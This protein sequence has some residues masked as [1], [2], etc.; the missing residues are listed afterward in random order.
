MK[1]EIS[2]I[3]STQFPTA[4]HDA[5]RYGYLYRKESEIYDS[6]LH[7]SL[8]DASAIMLWIAS[9]VASGVVYDVIKE[10]VKRLYS[11]LKERGEKVDKETET[12]LNDDRALEE[13]TIYVEEYYAHDMKISVEQE[14]Y[15]KEE[16]IADTTGVEVRKIYKETGRVVLTKE[17]YIDIR[18]KAQKRADELIHRHKWDILIQYS[19]YFLHIQFLCTIS[20]ITKKFAV[21]SMSI[22]S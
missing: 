5:V 1:Q 18:K 3:L 6:N 15:I 12:V 20:Q 22:Q 17:E 7:S 13:F 2:R 16:V 8:P 4:V 10:N 21:S 14:K 9:A 19:I 11:Y